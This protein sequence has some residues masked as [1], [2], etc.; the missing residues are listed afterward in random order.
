MQEMIV[1]RRTAEVKEERH[2]LFSSLL[3]ANEGLAENGEQLADEGLLGN[4]FIFMVAGYEV[5][6]GACTHLSY[7]LYPDTT[8]QTSA[9]TL[10][11]CFILLALYQDEQEKFYQN[12][13]QLLSDGHTPT[14]EE[15]STLSYAMAY[16]YIPPAPSRTHIPCIL[17]DAPV[18]S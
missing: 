5:S 8:R 17:S 11:Y 13:K 18:C 4:V 9:H 14:Y 1:A 12:I 16:V 7:L 2:D 15:F 6:Q 3:D 10:A